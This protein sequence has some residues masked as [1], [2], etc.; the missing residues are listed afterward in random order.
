MSSAV[1]S[2]YVVVPSPRPSPASQLTSSASRGKTVGC[3]P[4]RRPR[5]SPP[6]RPHQSGCRRPVGPC[7][8]RLT[9][10]SADGPCCQHGSLGRPGR[11]QVS[12]AVRAQGEHEAGLGHPLAEACSDRLARPE[13]LP[14]RHDGRP[15]RAAAPGRRVARRSRPSRGARRRS[16]CS[17]LLEELDRQ[18]DRENS[19]PPALH[20]RFPSPRRSRPTPPTRWPSPRAR[21]RRAGIQVRMPLSGRRRRP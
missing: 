18:G 10:P 9:Q 16:L 4:G 21:G 14:A 2:P 5:R 13:R 8:C 6:R 12:A 7:P 11:Y 17:K 15:D 3:R 1:A 19:G 20:E